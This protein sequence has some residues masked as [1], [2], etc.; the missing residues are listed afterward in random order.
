MTS[1]D[2]DTLA[3]PAARATGEGRWAATGVFFLN[4]LTL[5]TYIVRA[6]SLKSDNHLNDAQFGLI[7]LC[8]ALS[9]LV[10]MQFVG[11]WVARFGSRTVLRAVLLLMPVLLAVVAVA[12]G[13]V[14]LAVA[15]AALGAAHGTT[16]GAMNAHAVSIERILARP[17]LSGCHAAWSISAVI[18][19]LVAAGLAHAGVSFRGHLVA[20]AIVL[21][22]G[23]LLL[24]P[25]LRAIRDERA[26]TDADAVTDADVRTKAAIGWRN[27]WTRPVIAL[28]LT[29]MALMVGEGAALGWGPIFLHDDRG[30]SLGLAAIAVTAY[31]AGQTSVRMVGDRLSLRYGPAI[32]FRIGALVAAGGLALT[33]VPARPVVAV[34][35]LAVMGLGSSVLLP[36]T[37]SA[38]GQVDPGRREAAVLVSRFTTFTYAGIL[39]GPA[40]IGWVGELVGLTW[41]LAALVPVL[42]AVALFSRV[43]RPTTH[44]DGPA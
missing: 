22:A 35:G 28:G 12:H 4:G 29:G 16:D 11:P 18:A 14:E 7:G 41:T 31:T 8:F 39:L 13:L 23:G 5:S 1:Q 24:G 33:V 3:Q 30:A 25:R 44:A 43:S 15:A 40:V 17:I 34:L 21:L 38:I 2:Q 26:G 27:G 9:A 10:A 42:L 6:P 20:A 37:F 19:S 32:V 36:L